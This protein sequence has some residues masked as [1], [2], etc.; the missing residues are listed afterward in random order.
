MLGQAVARAAR[1]T[2]DAAHENHRDARLHLLTRAELDVADAQAVAETVERLQ[3]EAILN[4]AAWTDV[5]GAESD[6]DGAYAVNE[7]GAA[8][9]ARAAQQARAH[10]VHVSTDYVFAGTGD[11][12][13]VE[14]DATGSPPSV[15][16]AS[17]LAGEA[18]VLADP[19]SGFAVARTSWLFGAG[20]RNFVDTMLRLAREGR[21][22]LKVVDDQVGCPTWTGHLAPALLEIVQSRAAGVMHVAATGSCTWNELAREVFAQA[23]LDL[24]VLPQT[25]VEVNR[26]APRPANSVLRTE[27]ED[28]PRLPD[29][30]EGVRGHLAQTPRLEEAS[31]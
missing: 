27:R 8:N 11:S 28:I 22:E 9:L 29:W 1:E 20:G 14:S 23:G 19:Q 13:H 12:P 7:T 25:T 3:P 15:Y 31:R 26:L 17:K 6:P 16:G 10:L 4:L 18:R 30:R 5:D 24:E 21:I 2:R